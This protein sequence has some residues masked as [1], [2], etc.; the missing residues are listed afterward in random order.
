MTNRARIAAAGGAAGLLAALA[1][2]GCGAGSNLAT[3]S[4]EVKIDGKLADKGE[5][6][7][8]SADGTA[9]SAGGQ[10]GPDGR[11]TARVPLGLMKVEVRVSKV[12]GKKALYGKDG[13][14]QEVLEE[15]LPERYNTKTELTLD[16]TGNTTK[17]WHL[18]SK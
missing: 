7:F 10:I 3:V 1:L 5:V 14:Y 17:D 13:P 12:V 18:P 16:V 2:P 9:P 11:Y 6:A 8:L 15:I 4:G